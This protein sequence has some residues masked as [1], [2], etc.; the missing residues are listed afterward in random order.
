MFNL[1]YPDY[2]C[3]NKNDLKINNFIKG[4]LINRCII[5]GQF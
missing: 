4:D 3:L 2:K 1:N 5:L